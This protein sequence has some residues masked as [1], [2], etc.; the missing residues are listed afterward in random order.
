[1]GDFVV[2]GQKE[3]LAQDYGQDVVA[4]ERE[5][6]VAGNVM[7]GADLDD[8][9]IAAA[10]FDHDVGASEVYAVGSAAAAYGEEAVFELAAVVNCEVRHQA[11]ENRAAGEGHFSQLAEGGLVPVGPM[12]DGIALSPGRVGADAGDPGEEVE[13][14]Q[15]FAEDNG[16]NRFEG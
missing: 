9:E 4:F 1:V 5:G 2:V 12:E 3:S 6:N 7:V 14:A 15:D 8:T 13:I 11:L 10:W 16:R